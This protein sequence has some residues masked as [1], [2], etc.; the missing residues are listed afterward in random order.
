[1]ATPDPLEDQAKRP[2]PGWHRWRKNSYYL[3]KDQRTLRYFAPHQGRHSFSRLLSIKRSFQLFWV[4]S[5]MMTQSWLSPAL[6]QGDKLLLPS[7]SVT[8]S[9][10]RGRR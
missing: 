7:S 10:I 1:G 5:P 8:L 4:L 2:V 9:K 6:Q 3:L